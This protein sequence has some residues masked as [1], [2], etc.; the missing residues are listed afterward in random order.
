MREPSD[1]FGPFGTDAGRVL[2]PIDQPGFLVA[3]GDVHAV[4]VV[5]GAPHRHAVTH[6]RDA[7]G[8]GVGNTTHERSWFP[9]V[10]RSAHPMTAFVA[11]RI[12]PPHQSPVGGD[13]HV[14][15]PHRV[16]GDLPPRAVA[17]VVRPH[18]RG[19]APGRDQ[20]QT[21][22]LSIGPR[23]EADAGGGEPSFPGGLGHLAFLLDVD[24]REPIAGMASMPCRPAILSVTIR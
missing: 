22:G 2:V 6:H 15:D 19:A 24:G 21:V 4:V 18:L 1:A 7:H 9:A 20:R 12:E 3:V 8:P 23:G 14:L 17:E 13:H 16:V 5:G 10:E 11:G